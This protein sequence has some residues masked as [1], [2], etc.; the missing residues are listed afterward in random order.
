MIKTPSPSIRAYHAHLYYQDEVSLA[1]AK[2]VAERASQLFPIQV[3]HFHERPVGPH[4]VWSCQLSFAPQT[5][6]QI[7]PWLMLNRQNLD[8]FL[9]PVTDNNY[10]DH[11]QGVAWLGRSYALDIS[12]FIPI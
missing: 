1:L 10:F 9:H 11:T 8:V 7:V 3:G 6:A 5:F 12:V 4:P 2:Q